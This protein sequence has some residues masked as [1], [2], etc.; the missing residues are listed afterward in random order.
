MSLVFR[1]EQ[2]FRKIDLGTADLE[3][4]QMTLQGRMWS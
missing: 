1:R 3:V 4:K 2:A